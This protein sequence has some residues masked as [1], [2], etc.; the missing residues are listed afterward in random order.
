VIFFQV[1]FNL[2]ACRIKLL[3]PFFF[4]LKSE[5]EAKI[6]RKTEPIDGNKILRVGYGGPCLE[7]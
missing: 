2:E 3:L 1:N 7:T 6:Q 4:H 5:M